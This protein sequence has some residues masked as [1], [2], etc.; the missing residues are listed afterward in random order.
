MDEGVFANVSEGLD[1]VLLTISS[2]LEDSLS[3]SPLVMVWLW[4]VCDVSLLEWCS[5]GEWIVN[6]SNSMDSSPSDEVSNASNCWFNAWDWSFWSA[7]PSIDTVR[8]KIF[9]KNPEWTGSSG[10]K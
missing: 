5:F 10:D 8:P 7:K 2:S 4:Q 6:F 9:W 3:S 1:G